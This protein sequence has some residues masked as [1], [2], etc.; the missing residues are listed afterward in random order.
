MPE[1][2]LDILAF[3]SKSSLRVYLLI[4]TFGFF[5]ALFAFNAM[6]QPRPAAVAGAEPA[7]AT[8]AAAAAS[9][10]HAKAARVEGGRVLAEQYCQSCHLLPDPSLL[11][12][13]TWERG[14]LPAMG[15]RLGIFRH[16]STT[17]PYSKD[18]DEGFYP[19]QP[20]LT[21]TQ[22]Q[23]VIDYYVAN[24]PD[25]MPAQRREQAISMGLSQFS[26]EAPAATYYEPVVSL[27]KIMDGADAGRRRLVVS[28]VTKELTTFLD[29]ALAPVDAIKTVGAVV[30]MEFDGR[31]GMLACNIGDIHPNNDAAGR[32]QSFRLNESDR[33]EA[34]SFRLFDALRRPAQISRADLN[35]DG[36]D[37][38]LVCEFGFLIGGLSWM[39][40]AADG[41][42]TKHALSD[43][44]GP[45]RTVFEDVNRD[46]RMDFWVLFTQGQ[47]GISLFTNRGKG[48]FHQEM[49]LRFPAVYGSSYFERVDFDGDGHGD[50]LYTCGDNAD[51]TRVLKPY[52]GVYVFLND[53]TNHFRQ[54]YFFPVHGCYKA[55]A[56]DFDGDGDQDIASIA[57][58]ADFARQPEE[59]FVYLE[60]TGDCRFRPHSLEEGKWGRWLTMDAGDIDGDGDDDLVLGNFTMLG[61]VIKSR[62]DWKRAPQFLLFRNNHKDDAAAAAA[63]SSARDAVTAAGGG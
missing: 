10:A 15:P 12:A 19:S 26:V 13:T 20:Q 38:Y 44:P 14:A 29:A 51:Q 18:I 50:I 25:M 53:G 3:R 2:L 39:E 54:K 37:D 21:E 4:C 43:L 28:D 62:Y 57:F 45:I 61:S 8:A 22:W 32:A 56:R 41:T 11:D 6:H 48:N 35:D 7:T 40:G 36:I 63:A 60:N 47:E 23:S 9:A 58:F 55:V 46:G 30:N 52:H 27:V 24:A 17:Y 59:A 31:G 5:A 16:G 42:F 34:E 49:V 1:R 33:L